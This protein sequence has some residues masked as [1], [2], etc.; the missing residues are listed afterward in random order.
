MLTRPGWGIV[1]IWCAALLTA[2]A[3]SWAEGFPQLNMSQPGPQQTIPVSGNLIRVEGYVPPRHELRI[4][5]RTAPVSRERK[6][7]TELILPQGEHAIDVEVVDPAGQ[8]YRETKPVTV[9]DHYLFFV[10]LS[11]AEL[12]HLAAK[13]QVGS[14][15]NE[16]RQR[17][18]R[19]IYFDGRVAYYLKA[20]VKGKYLVTSS[21]DIDRERKELFRN[22]EPEDFYPIYGD[23]STI[24]YDAANTQDRL[25]LLVES[26]KSSFLWGN[27]GTGL[28]GTEFARYNRTLSGGKLHYESVATSQRGD[29]NTLLILF[30]A[31]ARQLAAHDDL[32]GTGGS[33]YYL[34]NKDVIQGSEKLSLE[35]RDETTGTTISRQ[36]LAVGADYEIDYDQGRLLMTRPVP[37]VSQ[38]TDFS[39]IST[40]ILNGNPVVLVAE[41][42]YKP[43]A[44]MKDETFGSR[45]A[46]QFG[47]VRLGGTLLRETQQSADYELRGLDAAI[48]LPAQTRVSGEYALSQVSSARQ[49]F[50]SD[51]GI[52]FTSIT[53]PG[54]G[55]KGEAYKI[56]ATAQ[57]FK[58]TTMTGFHRQVDQDFSNTGSAFEAGTIKTGGSVTQRL[59]PNTTVSASHV[60]QRL[61]K[62]GNQQSSQ[63]V[64]SQRERTTS[65]Q[66]THQVG[67]LGLTGEYRHLDKNQ[68]LNAATKQQQDLAA[69]RVSYQVT[70][71]WNVYAQDQVTLRGD[72][73]NQ[74]QVGT[75][76][77]L[78]DKT[79]VS[80]SQAVGN[81]GDATQFGLERQLDPH[82][83][84]YT[85]YT[86]T[87]QPSGLKQATTTF[88]G[89]T[90]MNDRTS[91]YTEQE[92][93]TY[94][95]TT[96]SANILGAGTQVNDRL[97]LDASVERSHTDTNV[98]DST[99]N[100]VKLGLNYIDIDWIKAST[101]GELRFTEAPTHERQ[102]VTKNVVELHPSKEW[103]L[104]GRYE[105]A[106]TRNTVTD[107]NLARFQELHLGAAYRPTRWDWL[108]W[109]GRY[110]RLED[111]APAS[112]ADT[113]GSISRTSQIYSTEAVIDLP[114]NFELAEKF[115]RRDRQEQLAGI[116]GQTNTQTY[117]W[118]NRLTYHLT[119]RW[120]LIGEYRLL[121]QRQADDARQGVLLEVDRN[122]FNTVRV[123]AGYNFT[124]FRDDLTGANDFDAHGLFVRLTGTLTDQS[125]DD[126]Q[127]FLQRHW[128]Q[129]INAYAEALLRARLQLPGDTTL[130]EMSRDLDVARQA[131]AAGEF[132][133]ALQ[134]Y[135]QILAKHTALRL[136]ART[137]IDQHMAQEAAAHQALRQARQ[138]LR[139]GYLEEAAAQFQQA[140]AQAQGLRQAPLQ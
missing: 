104:L 51:G 73:S 79:T 24:N 47:P 34:K 13:G 22:L 133:T 125:L 18:E 131:M 136:H 45:V 25:Y 7:S 93:R 5:D 109:L 82:S 112:Q 3:P 130:A 87:Q 119:D 101:S 26:G 140:K 116:A 23:N 57:P 67:K 53:Q 121:R 31:A 14:L 102:V 132:E 128:E 20:K 29:P 42:E 70:P 139:A 120:N 84:L 118:V 129:K 98:Q 134:R 21:Y 60:L 115:A 108:N 113:T 135:H 38:G 4:N 71:K 39:I 76:F 94:P 64:G 137:L 59:G 15:T 97:Y 32:R 49:N 99:N 110:V 63:N 6:F 126:V 95:G 43:S 35:I 2:P 55:T 91:L 50:S 56:E 48:D 44:T 74:G 40:N 83:S 127:R 30:S 58:G 72:N 37:S 12:G 81:Q 27:Y 11:E 17:M 138:S 107:T 103:S 19:E 33:L 89:R 65:V 105:Y 61:V 9:N 8:V 66:A 92:Y 10:S 69:A 123:G 41:Y 75:T 100:A 90:K 77:A 80:L 114:G 86:L 52:T 46:R 111:K 16:D 62:D 78:A 85:H 106:P 36:P 88:G 54:A 122:F 1:G 96:Q 28:T 68:P 124:N 117:L